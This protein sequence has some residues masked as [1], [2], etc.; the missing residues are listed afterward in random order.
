MLTVIRGGDVF[1]PAPLG[2]RDVLACGTAIA[3]VGAVDLRALDAIGVPYDVVDASGC[4]VVPGLI[5]PHQHLIGG[6]GESGF[7]SQTPEVRLSELLC[8]GITTVVGCLGV[9]TTTR[10][11]PALLA[12]AKSLNEYGLTAYIYSGGY[13]VPPSTLTGSVRTDMLFIDEVIGAGE[14]AISDRRSTAPSVPE[15]SR[16]V[17]DAAAGGLLTGKA[18]VTHFHLGDEPS[19]LAPLRA[20]LDDCGIDPAW[21]YPT[22]VERNKALMREAVDLSK[23]GVTVDVDVVERD[24]TTWVQYFFDHGGDT[25]HLTASS[26]ASITSPQGLFDE[27]RRCVTELR[28]PLE[29]VLPIVTSNTARVLKLRQ[30]GRI[31][32]G[33]DADVI[34]LRQGSLELVA[35]VSRGR[36]LLDQGRPTVRETWLENSDRRFVIDGE[37]ESTAPATA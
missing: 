2:R 31:A 13:N 7:H 28:M 24:L 25:D 21:I 18:G 33:A 14:I 29:R 23:R 30:K 5:D 15:L 37:K 11:M 10:A 22:H 12:K 32:T 4:V 6:S 27:I 26:D 3:A 36:V 1:A 35:V 16:L 8:A 9:D 19:R 34:A 20:L 17:R